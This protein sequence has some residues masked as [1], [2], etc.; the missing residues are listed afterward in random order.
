MDDGSD[1]LLSRPQHLLQAPLGVN[2]KRLGLIERLA[3]D[4]LRARLPLRIVQALGEDVRE[5]GTPTP[6]G[7]ER[8]SRILLLPNYFRMSM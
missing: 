5:L 4:A 6:W 7:R 2:A 8:T 1:R 3:E